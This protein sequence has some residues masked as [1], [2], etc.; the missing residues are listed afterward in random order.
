M[1]TI[2]PDGGR[3]APNAGALHLAEDDHGD[4]H[5][6]WRKLIRSLPPKR[7]WVVYIQQPFGRSTHVIRY[8]GRYTH[9]IGISDHR[10]ISATRHAIRFRTREGKTCSVAPLEFVR[11]F[12]LHVLPKGFH[13]IRH[14]GLYGTSN[15]NT[16]LPIAQKLLDCGDR[17]DTEDD[18]EPT[19]PETWDEL[20]ARLTQADPLRCHKCNGRLRY[21]RSLPSQ[22]PKRPP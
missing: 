17:D 13:K 21:D 19:T 15:V 2:L 3:S 16:R 4:G 20:L 7:K 6:A 9:R 22:R 11:R 14:F 8:L 1:S 12:M 10:L 18:E 5:E